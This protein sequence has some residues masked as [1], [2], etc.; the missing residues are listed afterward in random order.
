MSAIPERHETREQR[1]HRLEMERV[2]RQVARGVRAV[3]ALLRRLEHAARG[4]ISLSPAQ[5]RALELGL[6]M[7]APFIAQNAG[8]LPGTPAKSAADPN[9]AKSIDLDRADP[10]TLQRALAAAGIDPAHLVEVA[11]AEQ[12]KARPAADVVPVHV[13]RV[14]P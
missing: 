14:S 6:R 2:Q 8:L 9:E 3:P 11:A 4:K 5:L 1:A 13:E 12:A 10:A 7:F